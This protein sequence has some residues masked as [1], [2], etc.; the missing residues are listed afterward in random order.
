MENPKTNAP[1]GGL[2]TPA[3]RADI[4]EKLFSS[5]YAERNGK[6]IIPTSKGIQ[7]VEL[8]PEEL[9]SA[10]LTAD[11]EQQLTLISQGKANSDAFIAEMRKYSAELVRQVKF[12]SRAYVHDNITR[13]RCPDCSK[14]LLE[15]KGKRGRMLVCQDR[16]CGYRKNLE[17]ETNARCPNCHKK[18]KLYGE[19]DNKTFSCICGYRE[20]MA[21]F[22]KRRNTS[23][24]NK[25]DVRRYLDSQHKE[26]TAN[27]AL[28]DQLA[29]WQAKNKK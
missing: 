29:K 28:A 13:E 27:T 11:W 19:G 1:S 8:V 26:E 10:E 5:F 21:A 22:Q 16:E 4:I 20:K 2:G 23:S 25:N 18:L 15:V 9:R 12:S 17:I 24:A 14:F 3:T 7:L 6:E